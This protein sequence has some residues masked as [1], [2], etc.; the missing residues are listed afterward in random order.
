MK[1]GT[2]I[3]PIANR[4]STGLFETRSASG[5]LLSE[6]IHYMHPAEVQALF[7]DVFRWLSRVERSHSRL[8]L[9]TSQHRLWLSGWS[10]VTAGRLWS[11]SPLLRRDSPDADLIAAAPGL[12]TATPECSMTDELHPIT[13]I[14]PA[15]V[16]LQ[17]RRAQQDLL[18]KLLSIHR[19]RISKF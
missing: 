18:P 14:L 13:Y 7:V 12:L 15:T 19:R 2:L 10:S 17:L 9:C 1:L 8:H 4:P 5:A 16:R 6:L 11:C 3:S